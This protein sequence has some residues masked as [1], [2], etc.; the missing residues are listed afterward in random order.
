MDQLGVHEGRYLP[1]WMRK[2]LCIHPFD[3]KKLQLAN[4]PG[5]N[6]DMNSLHTL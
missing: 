1:D 6:W 4:E 5:H 2:L 3:K